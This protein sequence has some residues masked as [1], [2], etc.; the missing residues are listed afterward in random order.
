MNYWLGIVGSKL[1]YGRLINGPEYWFCMP[2]A[3]EIGD[4]IIMYSSRKAAGINSGIFGF[5]EV[6]EKDEQKNSLC[7]QY[8]YLSGTGEKLVYIY[9][10]KIKVVNTLV[11]FGMIKS[12]STLV[13]TAY[14]RRQMQ[15]TYFQLHKREFQVMWKMSE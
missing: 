6:I 5:Y 7:S 11:T 14:V 3:C 1:T 12:N 15:A 13:D 8:G 9:L 10:K 4:Q 2:K